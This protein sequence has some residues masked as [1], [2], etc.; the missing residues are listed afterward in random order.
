MAQKKHRTG[1]APSPASKPAG[2]A[3]NRAPGTP[4]GTP[5]GTGVEERAGA[6]YAGEIGGPA[7]PEP[8]RYGDWEV[9]GRCTDF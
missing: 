3:D 5:D 2:P 4:D 1:V 7:G 9:G 8:T 6:S